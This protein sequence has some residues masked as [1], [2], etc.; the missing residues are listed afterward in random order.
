MLKCVFFSHEKYENFKNTERSDIVKFII[1]AGIVYVRILTNVRLFNYNGE[2]RR[3]V[4]IFLICCKLCI[5]RDCA[6]H[7][8]VEQNKQDHQGVP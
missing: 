8:H 3:H 5:H 1:S 6:E 2:I 4:Y 7:K